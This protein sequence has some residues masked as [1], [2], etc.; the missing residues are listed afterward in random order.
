MAH[1]L[2]VDD[3]EKLSKLLRTGLE[4]IGHRVLVAG[5]GA[6]A[7][8]LIGTSALDVVLLDFELPDTNGPALCRRIREGTELE[9]AR[10]IML[11]AR[12]DE[13]SRVEAFEAGA[14]DYVTKPFSFRELGLRIRA[15]TEPPPTP[16]PSRLVAG[17]VSIDT[18]GLRARVDGIP[19]DL[20]ASEFALLCAI[21]R[22]PHRLLSRNHLASQVWGAGVGV[23]E[24][25]VDGL[26]RRLRTKL[27][28]AGSCIRVVR[29]VGYRFEVTL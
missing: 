6:E 12:A 19:M 9:R 23:E 17:R 16:R 2:S 1:I 22:Q 7:L 4:A 18:V 27:G 29:G 13:E 20:S 26:M 5:S 15:V 28:S 11:T 8:T 14:D 3:D 10:V 24:R 21:C 25:A